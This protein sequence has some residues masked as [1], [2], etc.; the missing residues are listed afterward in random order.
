MTT[1]MDKMGTLAFA[2]AV[3]RPDHPEA[4][5]AS[6]YDTGSQLKYLLDRYVVPPSARRGQIAVIGLLC[7]HQRSRPFG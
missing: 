6:R 4:L 5:W 3:A 7:S 1:Q 2:I